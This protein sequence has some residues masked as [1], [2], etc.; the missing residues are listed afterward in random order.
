MEVE[1]LREH[2]PRE[3]FRPLRFHFADGESIDV[4]PRLLLI[5]TKMVQVGIPSPSH[6]ELPHV[7]KTFKLVHTDDM[8][9]VDLF[10]EASTAS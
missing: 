1:A 8:V 10:A 5:T 9:A 7:F 6:P 4:H 2:Q 3:P